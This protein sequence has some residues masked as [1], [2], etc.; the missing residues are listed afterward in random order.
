MART[1]GGIVR[2]LALHDRP[3]EKLAR[4]GAR[5]LGDNELLAIVLA[6]GCGGRDVL[7][8]AGDLLAAAGGVQGLPGLSPADLVRQRGIGPAR[9]AQVLAAL[10]L[11]R[12]TLMIQSSERVRLSTPQQLASWLIPQF[13]AARVE[14]FGIV[15]LDT[16]HRLIRAAVLS[17]GSL[18]ATVVH[19]REVYR[20]AAGASASAIVLFH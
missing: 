7:T 11:G 14:Q 4:H 1:S 2:D 18:D 16:R 8:L 19:P 15:M 3:R 20:E 10:E 6:S 13:G 17:V 9:A 12:R 5:A